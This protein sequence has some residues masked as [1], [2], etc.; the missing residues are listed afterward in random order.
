MRSTTKTIL[1]VSIVSVILILLVTV[2]ALTGRITLND[3]STVGNT[4]GNLNNNGYFCEY[5][6]RVYFAN[7]YETT[8]STP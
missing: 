2:I 7:A 8:P 1:V 5:D 4:A 3:E 6:G